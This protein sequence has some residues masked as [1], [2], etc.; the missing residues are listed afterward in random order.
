MCP[1]LRRWL[2]D[3]SFVQVLGEK[4]VVIADG[5]DGLVARVFN[6]LETWYI[7]RVV[8]CRGKK[9]RS[10]FECRVDSY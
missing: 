5:G 2:N 6:I 8:V 3:I 10:A 9:V 1:A 4:L 7:R